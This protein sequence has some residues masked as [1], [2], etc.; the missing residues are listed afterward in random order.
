MIANVWVSHDIDY[1]DDNTQYYYLKHHTSR[2]EVFFKIDK[3]VIGLGDT[4]NS[5]V[6]R[7]VVESH[8]SY[9][10]TFECKEPLSVSFYTMLERN[11]KS[12]TYKAEHVGCFVTPSNIKHAWH[13][14][15][16][17]LDN[18]PMDTFMNYTIGYFDLDDVPLFHNTLHTLPSKKDVKIVLIG[19]TGTKA[20]D[21]VSN[22]LKNKLSNISMIIHVGDMSYATNL[23]ECWNSRIHDINCRYDCS[24]DNESCSG[25]D[26]GNYNVLSRWNKFFDLMGPVL[27]RIPIIT[28]MGNHDNDLTWFFLFRPPHASSYPGVSKYSN[29]TRSLITNFQKKYKGKTFGTQQR[30][31]NTQLQFPYF[32]S[33][34]VGFFHIL[35][36][37]S[38]DNAIN[39]YENAHPEY[40]IDLNIENTKARFDKHFGNKS[41][42][43]RFIKHDLH[44]INKKETPYTLVFSHR[45]L[46]HSSSHHP[47]CET[48][49]DWYMCWLRNLYLPLLIEYNVDL[50]L[51]GHSHHYMRSKRITFYDV[52]KKLL[53]SNATHGLTMVILGIGGFDLNNKFLYDADWIASRHGDKFGYS[54]LNSTHLITCSSNDEKIFDTY[55]LY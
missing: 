25:Y 36:Y 53:V 5:F 51:S 44:N 37:Q 22:S 12:M 49:G 19:D 27:Y 2:D 9:R 20:L 21:V 52:D 34:N 35:S 32:Y 18:L 1:E 33:L 4:S 46:I 23:G 16:V 10:E 30:F 50:F 54:Y 14:F 13:F 55:K 24:I 15:V 11:N 48:G 39:P 38:E 29:E 28:T 40:F 6:I 8:S 42:Q 45:P 41:T 43:F 47:S 31:L 7:F 17:I 26:R 3:V